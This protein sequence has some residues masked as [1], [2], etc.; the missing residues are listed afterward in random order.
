MLALPRGASCRASICF[1]RKESRQDMPSGRTVRNI[2]L[3]FFLSLTLTF[4][5]AVLYVFYPVMSA[6]ISALLN[7]RDNV[8]GVGGIGVVVGGVSESLLFV[9]LL[10][11]PLLFLLIFVLLQRRR[12]AAV[13]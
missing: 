10:F 5:V 3:A 8:G 4:V 7:S 12:A 2:F 13:P 11:E 1:F 9:F 6:V